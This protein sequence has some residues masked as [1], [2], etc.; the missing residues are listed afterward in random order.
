MSCKLLTE[1][2]APAALHLC[3][4]AGSGETDR[5]QEA[6]EGEDKGRHHCVP[7]GSDCELGPRKAA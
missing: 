7:L 6:R 3:Q 1:A 5:S 4:L 2:S